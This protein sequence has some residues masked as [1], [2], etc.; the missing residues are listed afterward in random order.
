[1]KSYCG[2]KEI[3]LLICPFCGG[4]PIV[5]HIGNNFTKSRKVEIKCPDCRIKR[6]DAALN[7]DFDWLEKVAIE[8]W[9]QRIAQL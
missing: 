7:H 8:G 5:K 1:M 2:K 6:V 9:N 3:D 4:K